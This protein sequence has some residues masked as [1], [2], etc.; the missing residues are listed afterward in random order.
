MPRLMSGFSVYHNN[1]NA[2]FKI[3]QNVDSRKGYLLLTWFSVK[4]Y[5]QLKCIKRKVKWT[6]V[7]C[8][9]A[10]IVKTEK[11]WYK[12][13]HKKDIRRLHKTEHRW[14]NYQSE[15]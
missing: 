10:V 1:F 12:K 5:K 11:C 3:N 7:I 15:W 4:C 2:D 13:K 6:I 14:R 8:I 9:N